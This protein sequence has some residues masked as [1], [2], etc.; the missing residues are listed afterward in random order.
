MF[1][2]VNPTKNYE[3]YLRFNNSFDILPETPLTDF[4]AVDPIKMYLI[5]LNQ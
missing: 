1:S 2:E 3:Y 4:Q 5:C